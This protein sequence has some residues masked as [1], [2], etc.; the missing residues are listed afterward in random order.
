MERSELYDRKHYKFGMFYHHKNNEKLWVPK[1][2]GLGWTLNFANKW[3]YF[4][5][6]LLIGS[7]IAVTVLSS[8]QKS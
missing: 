2:D 7:V 5:L 6:A 8:S 3:S 1:G 4:V